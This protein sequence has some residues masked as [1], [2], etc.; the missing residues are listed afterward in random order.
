LDD[1]AGYKKKAE[2]VAADAIRAEFAKSSPDLA[3]LNAEF[4]F[5]KGVQDVAEA[6]V[7]REAG[8]I[9]QQIVPRGIGLT[10]GVLSG[11]TLGEKAGF[12]ALGFA[13]GGKAVELFGSTGWKT[14][15]AVTK[16]RL[17]KLVAK[18]DFEGAALL[19]SKIIEGSKNLLQE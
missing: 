13:L 10:A 6:T 18:G 17:A 9:R 19:T 16:N 5:W 14:A 8:K 11:E 1:I 3:K 12:G 7:A 15:S 4:T 2:R